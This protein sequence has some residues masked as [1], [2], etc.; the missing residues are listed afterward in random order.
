M[1]THRGHICFSKLSIIGSD[2]VLLP[3]R[4]QAIIWK[5]QCCTFVN[6][7]RPRQNGRHFAVDIFKY[8]ILNQNAWMSLKISLKVQ[9]TN[10]PALVQIMAWR[11]PVDKLLSEPIIVSLLTHMC[12]T[13]PQWVNWNPRDNFQW[14][15]KRKSCIFLQENAFANV[16]CKMLVISYRPQ[17]VK[18]T[19]NVQLWS[20]KNYSWS[21]NDHLWKSIIQGAPYLHLLNS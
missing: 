11:R 9:I 18:T 7:L 5:K 3:D 15:L 1:L 14:N 2:N 17:C 20:S 4:K 8:I 13:Q 19:D 16:V 6:T 21:S 12:I 10:I